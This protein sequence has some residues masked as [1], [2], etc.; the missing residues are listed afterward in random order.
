MLRHLE[1]NI[2]DV[3][4]TTIVQLHLRLEQTCKGCSC[5]NL[6][7]PGDGNKRLD[8]VIRD[9]LKVFREIVL[10]PLWLEHFDFAFRPSFESFDPRGSE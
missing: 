4:S 6:W 9:Y 1:F 2:K 5:Y 10:N 8:L 7:K 3:Q